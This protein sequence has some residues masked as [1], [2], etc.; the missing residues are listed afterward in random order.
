MI[1]SGGPRNSPPGTINR[2][3]FGAL[4]HNKP[5]ALQVKVKGVFTP[6]SSRTLGD[7]VRRVALGLQEMGIQQGETVVPR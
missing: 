7:R 2:L 5:D 4:A 1:V 3:F 6:I